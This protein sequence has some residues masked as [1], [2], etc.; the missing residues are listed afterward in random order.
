VQ[1]K[2]VTSLADG[3]VVGSAIINTIDSVPADAPI[4]ARCAKLQ[5]RRL[6]FFVL[7]L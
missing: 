3:V 7:V 6:E 1:V 2:E 4:E 5:V